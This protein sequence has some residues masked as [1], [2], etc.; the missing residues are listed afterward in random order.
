MRGGG[1]AHLN[2]ELGSWRDRV[3]STIA[4]QR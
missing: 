4:L 1:L 2:L 3:G